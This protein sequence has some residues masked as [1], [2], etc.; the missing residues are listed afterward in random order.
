MGGNPLA[1]STMLREARL[2]VTS[3][4]RCLSALPA[5]RD[6]RRSLHYLLSTQLNTF[7]SRGLPSL[8]DFGSVTST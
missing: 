5:Q 6:W 1:K 3:E 7:V 4:V 2:S 8:T